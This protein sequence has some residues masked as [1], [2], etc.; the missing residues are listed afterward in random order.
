MNPT[1]AEYGNRLRS[2]LGTNSAFGSPISDESLL[3]PDS[4][5][6]LGL[7]EPLSPSLADRAKRLGIIPSTIQ[8]IDPSAIQGLANYF[9]QPNNIA[10]VSVS[11]S[12][13][14][15][16]TTVVIPNG[17][18]TSPSIPPSTIPNDYT[19][20]SFQP[21]PSNSPVQPSNSPVNS[22]QFY[23]PQ[24]ISLHPRDYGIPSPYPEQ[25]Y[26]PSYQTP[27][28]EM[29]MEKPVTNKESCKGVS[30]PAVVVAVLGG[31][32]TIIAAFMTFNRSTSKVVFTVAMLGL[33]T[34]V[35]TLVCWYL[36]RKCHKSASWWVAI[37]SSIVSITFFTVFSAMNL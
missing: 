19:S 11:P 20:F 26:S 30:W 16:A 31:A 18:P 2:A 6:L 3:S 29:D 28:S 35:S 8:Q 15:L 12:Q 7:D 9:S 10:S 17:P 32:F 1:L 25:V 5:R 24:D 14:P 36:W 27:Y 22:T 13:G 21:S 4:R 23:S 33:W 34:L 37:I